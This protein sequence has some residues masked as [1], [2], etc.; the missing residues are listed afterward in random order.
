MINNTTGE[1]QNRGSRVTKY[2]PKTTTKPS[3]KSPR[4]LPAWVPVAASCCRMQLSSTSSVL[5]TVLARLSAFLP[6]LPSNSEHNAHHPA[7]YNTLL[8]A[9][10]SSSSSS[11]NNLLLLQL[12]TI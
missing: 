3:T 8:A 7:I 11:S 9:A 4:P 6:V 1:G 5:S 10:V 2:I 12:P